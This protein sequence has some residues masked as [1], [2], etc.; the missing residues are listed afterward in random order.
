LNYRVWL[1]ALSQSAWST[2]AGWGLILTYA[3]Y[4]KEKEKIIVNSTLTGLGNNIASIICGLAVIPTVFALSSSTDQAYAA[5]QSGNQ[6][7]TFIYIPQLFNNMLG[8]EYFTVIFF[9]ALFIAALSSLIA[10][11]ELASR[12]FIDYGYIRKKAVIIVGA[13]TVIAGFPSA[14]SLNFFNNQDWVWGVGLLLSGFFFIIF[15]LKYGLQNFKINLI[16]YKGRNLLY[17]SGFLRFLIIIMV[18]E[19]LLMFFWWFFQSISW[20][21]HTWWNP[22][23]A[24]TIG[25]CMMQWIIVLFS[26]W[27]LN[28]KL[29][30]FD[31][32][33]I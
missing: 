15:A 23:G 14:F 29:S 16:G 17:H 9:F 28:N 26:G 11:L 27:M 5:L 22:F 1:E 3:A 31:N 20:Y 25:T 13:V 6:G 33:L 10:M 21:P 18:L 2:G 19:F 30:K 24:F 32:Q 8:G 4:V 7:L 12:L